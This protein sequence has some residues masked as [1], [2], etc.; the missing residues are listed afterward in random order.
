LKGLL[1]RG[2]IAGWCHLL[3]LVKEISQLLGIFRG[4]HFHAEM[5]SVERA[6]V[7]SAN[8][9]GSVWLVEQA[10]LDRNTLGMYPTR[11]MQLVLNSNMLR[12]F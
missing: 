7:S 4:L 2:I 6:S 11:Y 12:R 9:L 8:T 5:L 3:G 1:I 10:R